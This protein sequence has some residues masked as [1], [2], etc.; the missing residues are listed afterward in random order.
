MNRLIYCCGCLIALF[1]ATCLLPGPAN[2]DASDPRQ[3]WQLLDYISVDYRGAVGNGQIIEQAEY[4]EMQEFATTARTQLAA[5]PDKPGRAALL[6]AAANLVKAID[7]RDTPDSVARLS[8]EL[9]D[10]V[11]AT[12]SIPLAPTAVPDIARGRALYASDC[13]SCHGPAGAGDGV[14]AK[15]LDPA[16]VA[17]TDRARSR[18]RSPFSYYQT[19]SHGVSGTAMASFAGLPERDRWALAFFASTLSYSDA[20]RRDGE[21]LWR[22]KPAL[23]AA[24]PSLEALAQH[25]EAQFAST[26]GD[27]APS[28]VSFLRSAP[29]VLSGDSASG[30]GLVRK[31][32]A[33][34]IAA[35]EAGRTAE[36]RQL[37]LSAYLDGFEPLEPTLSAT[38][39]RLLAKVETAMAAYRSDLDQ[40]AS[41]PDVRAR[42][43]Q[44]EGLLIAVDESLKDRQASP[45]TAFVGSFTILLREGV[46]A[47]LIVVAI[48]AF[49]RKTN[50]QDLM[51]YVHTGWVGALVA[52]LLTWGAATY[53][54]TI[55]GANRETTEGISSLL[56]A[57][58]LLTVGLW[59][60]NKSLAGRWQEYLRAKLSHAV[61]QRSAWFL[62]GLAFVAVYREVFET[63]LFYAAIW[64]QGAHRAVIAGLVVAAL[65]LALIAVGLLRAT[66]R[67]PISQF[68]AISS[69]FIGILA[70]VLVGRGVSA[71]QEAG[72]VNLDAIH[73]PRL[74]V[75]GIYPNWQ[76]LLAQFA[77]VAVVLAGIA[78]NHARARNT[79]GSGPAK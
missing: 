37:A 51:P 43:T 68:F 31:R 16:P 28:V 71:L 33:D 1:M 63:I 12:Y 39:G 76:T 55:T 44:I 32:L 30:L 56:A 7:R 20:Q 25:S 62:G 74:D 79:G 41:L 18:E 66:R 53:L 14:L 22:E 6:E 10:K 13:T 27:D 61:S 9:A 58:I 52:G 11:L 49:L 50:R 24:V 64:T 72:W 47:L 26:L 19:I 35:Y 54:V 46:E 75:L 17:F 34:S 57:V 2:A 8:R 59:M 38:N 60:H 45:A 67:L 4:T 15:S 29:R 73:G 78:Y 21:R 77:V 3:V 42:A 48:V 69:V 40:H 5:L 70:V 36:A 23:H 65:A